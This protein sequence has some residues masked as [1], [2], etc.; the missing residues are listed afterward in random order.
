MDVSYASGIVIIIFHLK[1]D[2]SFRRLHHTIYYEIVS[3][4]EFYQALH[5]AIGSLRSRF[6]TNLF[7]CV[8]WGSGKSGCFDH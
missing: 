6:V 4:C 3:K 1:Y 8:K 7:R 2:V 5:S